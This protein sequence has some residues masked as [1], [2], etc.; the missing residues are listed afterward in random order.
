MDLIKLFLGSRDSN[1]ALWSISSCSNHSDT[2][3]KNGLAECV[4]VTEPVFTFSN[5][6]LESHA[7]TTS[8]ERVR[9]LAYC[10]HSYVSTN[11]QKGKN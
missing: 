8:E 10:Y 6:S 7:L 9:S 5:L 4:P 1:M 3:D 11:S 2:E